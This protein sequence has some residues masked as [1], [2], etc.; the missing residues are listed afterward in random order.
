[1]DKWMD[2]WVGG[3]M[4]DGWVDGQ[5]SDCICK[6]QLRIGGGDP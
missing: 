6:G 3:W 1:M 5:H 4:D 2:E